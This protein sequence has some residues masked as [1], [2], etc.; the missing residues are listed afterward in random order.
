MFQSTPRLTL[1][2]LL[3]WYW[4]SKESLIVPSGY[5]KIYW[6]NSG[7][8][9]LGE[10]CLDISRKKKRRINVYLPGYFCGQSL[11]YLRS[12]QVN[13]NFYEL[14]EEFLPNYSLLNDVKKNENIDVFV[15][16]HYFGKIN[17]QQKSRDFCNKCDAILIE[18]CAHI[19]SPGLSKKWRGDYL[20]FSPHKHFPLP[21]IA[22][23]I[24]RDKF[25]LFNH[26]KKEKF[27]YWWIFKEVIK[28]FLRFK[29]LVVW[30]RTW[31]KDEQLIN[32]FQS[33][34]TVMVVTSNYLQNYLTKCNQRK[35]NSLSLINVLSLVTDWSPL[36]EESLLEC[37]YLLGMICQSPQVAERRFALLNQNEQLVMQWPDLPLEIMKN[38]Q[39]QEQC[40]N[41]L[42]RTL[43]FFIH[44]Q[45]DMA[46]INKQIL[47]IIRKP[48]F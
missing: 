39:L 3:Q 44:Q 2:G 4:S 18:D 19:M 5:K 16:V 15:H 10:I 40:T 12:I 8:L 30:K 26:Y 21:A 6:R 20:I 23:I 37:P 28:K 45:L 27:P 42:D 29:K 33:N 9:S 1:S 35:I 13:L 38:L 36:Q 43:F 17:G 34:K 48:M 25:F 14:D 47:N 11:R 24:V 22:L 46:T 31:N 7:A 41:L 32:I